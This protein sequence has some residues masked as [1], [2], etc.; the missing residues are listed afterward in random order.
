VGRYR[1]LESPAVV[2]AGSPTGADSPRGNAIGS[3][4]H[5]VALEPGESARIVHMLGITDTVETIPAAVARWSDAAEV[6][7][8]F[9]ALQ[10]GWERYL[11]SFTVHPRPGHRRDAQSLEPRPVP[12]HAVLV[13]LRLRIRDGPGTRHGDA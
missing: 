1:G 10:A 2:E 4:C 8:A 5:E 6:S 13:A 3:F 9:A 7:R 12:H 11:S